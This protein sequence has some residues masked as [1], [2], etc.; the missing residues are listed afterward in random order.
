MY[1][2]DMRVSLVNAPGANTY[3]VAGFTWALLYQ[4]QKDKA[5]EEAL[6]RGEWHRAILF[7]GINIF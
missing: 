6:V 1:P 5:K 3:P 7:T 4:D 2:D